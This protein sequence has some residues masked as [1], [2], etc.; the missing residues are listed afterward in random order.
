MN[1]RKVKRGL[2][3]APASPYGVPALA[4]TDEKG[5][6]FYVVPGRRRFIHE[7]AHNLRQQGNEMHHPW[8][9]F[10]CLV[11]HMVRLWDGH[12]TTAEIG[13]G[14]ALLQV[15]DGVDIST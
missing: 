13:H 5:T 15:P 2:A 10:C 7:V 6:V 3:D 8:W 1:L 14:V 4:W 11:G 9:H 12:A